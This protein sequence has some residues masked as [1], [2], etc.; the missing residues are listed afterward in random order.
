M[1]TEE[2]LK[3]IKILSSDKCGVVIITNLHYSNVWGAVQP[4]KFICLSVDEWENKDSDILFH[5]IGQF[6]KL[7]AIFVWVKYIWII[8]D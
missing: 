3:R 4:D 1:F 5:S 7:F 8:T 6:N 2:L